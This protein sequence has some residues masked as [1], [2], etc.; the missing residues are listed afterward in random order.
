MFHNAP[1][2]LA[3]KRTLAENTIEVTFNAPDNFAFKA[4]QYVTITIPSLE[5]ETVPNKAHDF[6]I[7]SS[8]LHPDKISTV[9]RGSSSI[10]KTALL[11]LPIGGVVHLDGPKGVLGL[12]EAPMTP[13][14]FI[15]G[16]IGIT[17]I[18]SMI[19]F[20]TEMQS[21]RLMTL[22]YC[23]SSIGTTA[24]H[25]EIDLLLKQNRALVR[26]DIFGIP[27][28][29]DFEKIASENQSASW[30][31]VGNSGMVEKVRKI[32]TRLGI[33]DINIRTEEFSGYGK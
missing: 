1:I 3:G 28:E 21:P 7:S 5:G 29:K 19:R 9:F 30:F 18:L 27:E 22:I 2:F 11:S 33:L 31:I 15:A 12:P 13:V 10:F 4:G 24:Y 16:G 14:I 6:S 26:R 25:E 17:P 23:N 8:P 20:A 32:I